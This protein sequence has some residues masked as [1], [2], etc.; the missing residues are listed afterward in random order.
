MTKIIALHLSQPYFSAPNP[1]KH[2]TIQNHE[3]MKALILF[4]SLFGNTQKVAEA[5][6]DAL[7][8]DF[9]VEVTALKTIDAAH[10]NPPDLLI[11]G[12]PT[13]EFRPSPPT[14][15][16][17]H[18]IPDGCLE[19][20]PVAAFDTRIN[21]DS[22]KSRVFRFVV[23]TGG[24]AAKSIEKKLKMKG[25]RPLVESAGFEVLG[26]EGPLLDGELERAARWAGQ[27]ASKFP[28][29]AA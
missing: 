13:H 8:H 3:T 1:A 27:I 14:V 9:D 5:I 29:I 19:S 28:I 2:T 23:K 24:F 15:E 18:K 12:A 25:G 10:F 17:L 22:I 7:R 11:L 16:F 21:L 6:G 20:I 26:K 4:D